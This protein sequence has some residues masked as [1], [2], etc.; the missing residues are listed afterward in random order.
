MRLCQRA[1]SITFCS[2][3]SV[4]E[5]AEFGVEEGPRVKC[6]IN[7]EISVNLSHVTECSAFIGSDSAFKTMSAMLRIPTIV[8]MGDYKDKFRDENFIDPYVKAGVMSVVHYTDLSRDDEI[9]SGVDFSMH[10]LRRHHA[11]AA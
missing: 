8:W 7:K 4:R 2:S 5:L 3:G 10:Q 11:R 9:S 1:R 6:V